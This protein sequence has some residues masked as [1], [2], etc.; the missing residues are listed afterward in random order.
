MLKTL[1]AKL[2]AFFF[3]TTFIPLLIV[4]YIFYE[5]QKQQITNQ[6]EQM[7]VTHATHLAEETENLLFER[8]SDLKLLSNNPILKDDNTTASDI[9]KEFEKFLNVYDIYSD[10]IFV[11][12]DG[13]VSVSMIDH[14]IGNDFSNREWFQM[15]L[16]DNVYISDI[17]LS[18]ILNSP[19]LVMSAP[20]KNER[21]E[22]IGILSPSFNLEY[23]WKTYNR[24]LEQQQLF[25]L[26]G[27]AF[28]MNKSG[29]IIAHHD[30]GK[31]LTKNYL[32]KHNL[33]TVDLI[34][35]SRD[36][37]IHYDEEEEVI[38]SFAHIQS[39]DEFSH[40]WFVGISV[41]K[42][43]LFTPLQQMLWK[44]L[45]LMGVVLFV[46]SFAV[47]KLS[48]YIV[49][50]LERLV[51]ATSDFA[52]GRQVHQFQ[53]SYEEINRLNN[54]FMQMTKK[55]D[56]RER[57]HRKSTRILETTDNGVIAI[58]KQ[59]RKVTLFNRTCEQ[60]F[61][62]T[63]ENVIGR[64]IN[65]M[66]EVAPLFKRFIDSSQLLDHLNYEKIV[67]KFELQCQLGGKTYHFFVSVFV[68]TTPND[69]KEDKELL[70]VFNDL[71]EKRLMERELVRSEKLKVVGEMA[72]GLA[73]EIRNPLAII[74]GFIQLF[75][76]EQKST[77]K[78]YYDLIIKEIDRVNHFITDLLN[79]ANPKSIGES[80][81][82][83]IVYV[84]EDLLTLQK[85]QLNQKGIELSKEFV[86]IPSVYI[87]PSKFQQVCINIVQ[88]AIEVMKDGGK[89]TVGTENLAHLG[90]VNLYIE[91]TGEGMD[92]QT[93]QLLGT[94]FFT[95]KKSG[96][97]LGLTTSYRIIEEMNGTISV[98][99]EV[100]KGS[101]FIISIPLDRVN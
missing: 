65:E 4:G 22:I 66:M 35:I 33:T 53:E 24:F 13:T 19:I 70:I 31:I 23:L 82:T 47:I 85:S 99:S 69:E 88:N 86:E 59:T 51:D 28:L 81:E 57:G 92:E 58:H 44:F 39:L 79:I 42:E 34:E 91:D 73:H 98:F 10:V 43:V 26:S 62:I 18:P 83:N 1:R 94:P 45:L 68:L 27:Y 9:K 16:Q 61:S 74:R 20:V 36:E 29:D 49:T 100:G 8:V 41:P 38:L 76:Q 93:L 46:T 7:F 37:R 48:S 80:K 55:L 40:D 50:P 97:G 54:T 67:N 21:E 32:A 64:N 78:G 84:M 87:D 101:K 3:L 11:E 12:V 52:I 75:S 25:G 63:K 90:R 95:T 71:T 96:T 2:L 15:S 14:V 60:L 72:A 6:I 17:Y 56:E 5:S 30:H 77:K 89:L